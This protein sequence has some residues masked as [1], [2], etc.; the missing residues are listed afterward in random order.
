MRRMITASARRAAL[1][2]LVVCAFSSA[3]TAPEQAEST[4]PDPEV[5]APASLTGTV[6]GRVRLAGTELP[7][8]AV[9]ENTT[10]PEVCGRVQ[11]AGDLVVDADSRAIANVIVSLRDVPGE[12]VPSPVQPS[13]LVLDNRD[14]QFV[15]RVAV[16]TVGSTIEAVSHDDVLHT[17]HLYGALEHNIALPDASASRTVTVDEPGMIAVLCDVHGWMKAYVR[18]DAHPFHAVTGPDGT[19]AIDDVPA[20][21]YQLE[22]WHERLGSQTVTVRVER[23][24]G[25][26]LDIAYALEGRADPADRRLFPDTQ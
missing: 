15:P 11:R 7:A 9:I 3:C 21:S 12:H 10:D 4:R 20:G 17:V 2:V 13:R 18:V 6:R 24:A 14:C 16:L 23:G 25:D 1:G 19:F 26:E 22:V 8:P 5:S